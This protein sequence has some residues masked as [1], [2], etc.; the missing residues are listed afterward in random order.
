[1]ILKVIICLIVGYLCGNISTA[2]LIGKSKNIDFRKVGSGNL[3]TTNVMRTLGRKYGLLTYFGDFIKVIIPVVMVEYI[4][5]GNQDYGRLLGLITGYGCVIG[6]CYPFWLHFKGGKGIAAMSAVMAAFDPWIILIGVPLFF[7]IVFST[8]YVS[9]GS[10][11]IAVLFPVWVSLREVISEH[12]PYFIWMLIVTLLY[13]VTVF[14]M[15]RSNIQRLIEGTENKIGSGK[16][17]EHEEL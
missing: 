14:Y 13:T 11:T 12:N 2:W 7:I 4:I 1:M 15:H 3:G 8:K 5:F 9:L 6:H 16:D 17:K 10:L